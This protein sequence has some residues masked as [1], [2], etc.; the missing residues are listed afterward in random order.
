MFGQLFLKVLMNDCIVIIPAMNEE[1]SIGKVLD[2]LPKDHIREIVVADNGSTDRTAEVARAHG[3][4]VVSEPRPG[5]G[6]ACLAGIAYVMAKPENEKP[7]L[8][9]FVDADFSDDPTEL[10]MILQPIREDRADMVIGSR[11]LGESERGSL[12]PAQIFGNWLS[13]RLVKW[14]YNVTYTDLGPFRAIRYE[15]LMEMKMVDTNYGWTVEMQ[16]K[17]AKMGL[18]TAEVPVT[19]RRRIGKSKISGTVKGTVLAGTK[20]LWKIYECR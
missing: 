9:A 6:Q 4:T 18:K 20:I 17:A 19:Y 2:A 13:T 8:I 11:V 16:I 5:Y 3:A 10:P 15:S 14:L 12:T 7:P 1:K